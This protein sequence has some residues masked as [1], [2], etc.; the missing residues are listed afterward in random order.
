MNWDDIKKYYSNLEDYSKQQ[1]LEAKRNMVGENPSPTMASLVDLAL[2]AG[3]GNVAALNF[4]NIPKGIS[5]I[6]GKVGPVISSLSPTQKILL[7]VGGLGTG[8]AVLSS[9]LT[10]SQSPERMP[11]SLPLPQQILQQNQ[12]PEKAIEE[13]PKD[14]K[15]GS[16]VT[17]SIETKTPVTQEIPKSTDETELGRTVASEENL[18]KAQEER[19]RLQGIA[20]G[21][22]LAQD[23]VSTITRTPLKSSLWETMAKQG[24]QKVADYESLVANEKNDPNSKYSKIYQKTLTD[25]GIKVPGNPSAADLEKIFPNI[26]RLIQHREDAASREAMTKLRYAELGQRREE[27][28][29]AKEDQQT[30]KRFD[31]LGKRLTAETASSRSVFGK[32]ANIVRSAEA[33]ENLVDQ[34][35]GKLDQLDTRQIQEL[36]RSLDAILSQGQ[37]TITGTAHLVPKS[38][39]G[40]VSKIAEYITDMRMGAGQGDFVNTMIHTIKREKELAQDQVKKVQNKILG[41][42]SDLEKKD[43]SKFNT[44]MQ[45][46]GLRGTTTEQSTEEDPNVAKYAK[47]HNLNYEQAKQILLKRGYGK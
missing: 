9:A 18:R 46:Y 47:D 16:K 6:A 23:V 2:Q 17:K 22:Q 20:A 14:K 12:Q 1:E 29:T 28:A 37:P 35:N 42:Y 40:D 25:M 8:G 7:G 32:T 36:A 19:N 13:K 33:I 27:A 38:I 21:G 43:P 30:T 4:P 39:R 44:M 24:E 26:E 3:P 5:Q 15:S 34:Y 31:E 10:D 45:A 41:S 11:E